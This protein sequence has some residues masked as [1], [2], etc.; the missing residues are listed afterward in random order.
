MTLSKGDRVSVNEWFELTYASYAVL[1]R[2]ILQSMPEEWQDRFVQCMKELSKSFDWTPK[3]GQ[4][5]RVSLHEIDE[6]AEQQFGDEI[7]DPLLRYRNSSFK[8]VESRRK[9][10]A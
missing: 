2:S 10:Q 6:T 4:I 1:P 5:Y 9:T 3:E 8:E 7:P